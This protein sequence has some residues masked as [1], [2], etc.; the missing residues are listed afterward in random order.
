MILTTFVICKWNDWPYPLM[1][2][3][4]SPCDM[5]LTVPTA[6]AFFSWDPN[7]L[8]DSGGAGQEC[9][10]GSLLS[11]GWDPETNLRDGH[12]T[13]ERVG[14]LLQSGGKTTWVAAAAGTAGTHYLGRRVGCKREASGSPNTALRPPGPRTDRQM[15]CTVKGNARGRMG[16]GVAQG[17]DKGQ[18]SGRSSQTAC[19]TWS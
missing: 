9:G 4:F 2:W 5:A 12:R 15:S 13:Q 11:S 14:P 17:D 3:D 16:R 7:K 18:K 10:S 6:A 1:P 19:R 8:W